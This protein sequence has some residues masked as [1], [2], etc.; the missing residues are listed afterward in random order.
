MQNDYSETHDHT[1]T[2]NIYDQ[3]NYKEARND[4]TGTQNDNKDMQTT[5]Q[6]TAKRHN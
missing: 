2:Q 3:N 4:Y 5:T 1:E 6:D